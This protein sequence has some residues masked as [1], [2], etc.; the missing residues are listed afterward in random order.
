MKVTRIQDEGESCVKQTNIKQTLISDEDLIPI[1]QLMNF[2]IEDIEDKA[3]YSSK[4]SSI[5]AK[6]YTQKDY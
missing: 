2:I 3:K 6:L 5:Y 1:D 4:F